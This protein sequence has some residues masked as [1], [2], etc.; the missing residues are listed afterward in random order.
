MIEYL[1]TALESV[2]S[3]YVFPILVGCLYIVSIVS[4]RLQ[5][6]KTPLVGLSSIFEPRLVANYRFFKDSSSIINQG[7]S[8]AIIPCLA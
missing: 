4:V 2:A 6:P 1:S 5:G 8:K 3:F 7:Y